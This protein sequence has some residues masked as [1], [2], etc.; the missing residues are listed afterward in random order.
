LYCCKSPNVLDKFNLCG[1]PE[2]LD[3]QGYLCNDPSVLDKNKTCCDVTYNQKINLDKICVYKD[4]NNNA[5]NV[6]QVL[7]DDKNCCDANRIYDYLDKNRGRTKKQCC[8]PG[9]NINRKPLGGI[10]DLCS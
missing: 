9:K 7:D 3:N 4:K 1:N 6:G 5:C 8:P 2:N 10:N